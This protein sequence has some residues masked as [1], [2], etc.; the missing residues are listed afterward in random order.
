MPSSKNCELLQQWGTIAYYPNKY[1][2]KS[3]ISKDLIK[4]RHPHF[5]QNVDW[6]GETHNSRAFKVSSANPNTLIPSFLWI[7]LPNQNEG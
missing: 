7:S 4:A 3:I 6:S 2:I 1:T 5:L